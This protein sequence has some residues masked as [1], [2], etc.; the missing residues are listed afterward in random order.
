MSNGNAQ[1]NAGDHA[2]RRAA[3]PVSQRPIVAHMLHEGLP[4]P[5]SATTPVP[6]TDAGHGAEAASA[7]MADPLSPESL[8]SLPGWGEDLVG[9]TGFVPVTVGSVPMLA[10]VSD[11]VDDVR[12]STDSAA[13][14]PDTVAPVPPVIVCGPCTSSLDAAHALAAADALPEW[15]AVLA[16]SQRAGR[17][18]LRRPWESPPGNIYAAMRLPANGVFA[19]ETAAIALG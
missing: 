9:C 8:R 13:C 18:Q 4:L 14:R 15:G 10:A 6:A 19:T 16:V 11:M 3:T 2:A 7:W 17:G 1:C 5:P 12:P